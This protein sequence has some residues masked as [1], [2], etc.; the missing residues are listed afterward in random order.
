MKVSPPF[1]SSKLRKCMGLSS[2]LLVAVSHDLLRSQ[3]TT[4][5]SISDSR[6]RYTSWTVGHVVAQS[7][8]PAHGPNH[9]PYSLSAPRGGADAGILILHDAG[10]HTRLLDLS[11]QACYDLVGVF[12][13]IPA[14]L[15]RGVWCFPISKSIDISRYARWWYVILQKSGPNSSILTLCD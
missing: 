11:C 2:S 8:F 14:A 5:R 3:T 4:K 1:C 15:F 13:R 12:L 7:L 10:H 6:P 9:E